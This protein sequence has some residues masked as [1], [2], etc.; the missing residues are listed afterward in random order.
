MS[1]SKIENYA[2]GI[3]AEIAQ[4][5]GYD[6]YDVVYEK[7]GPHWFL[8]VYVESENGVNLDD[9][10]AISRLFSEILDKDDIIKDNYF[11]EISSPGLE[12]VL[13][14]D[15]HFD[16]AFG[17]KVFVKLKKGKSHEGVLLSHKPESIMLDD[18]TIIQKQDIKKVNI[19]FDYNV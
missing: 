11:L 16:K 9:C 5:K 12:R 3:V 2:L 19:I 7:E 1:Y 15:K 18:E 4:E 14:Q 13:T 6:I 10:E 17:E 8:R